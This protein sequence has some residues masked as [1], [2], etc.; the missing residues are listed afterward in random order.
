MRLDK[1]NYSYS[2][3]IIIVYE[4]N[5]NNV[6]VKSTQEIRNKLYELRKI[7]WLIEDNIRTRQNVA[8]G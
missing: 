1:E 6:F 8:A 3:Q 4:K 2:K 7:K 5:V